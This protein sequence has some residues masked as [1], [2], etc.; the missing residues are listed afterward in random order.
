MQ[1]DKDKVEDFKKLFNKTYTQMRN[2]DGC[3]FLELYQDEKDASVFF[4]VSK[5]EGS[6]ELEY[7]RNSDL[8]RNTWATTKTFFSATSEAYS[9]VR[10]VPDSTNP[11]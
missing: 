3:R 6:V 5:W 11:F 8:F 9:I 1:F 10:T 2:F 4:T 7:Y